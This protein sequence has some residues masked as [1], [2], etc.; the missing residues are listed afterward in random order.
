MATVPVW[1]CP[2]CEKAEVIKGVPCKQCG[3][4]LTSN[5]PKSEI[6]RMALND[7]FCDAKESGTDD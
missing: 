3:F 5:G 2:W 4:K 1:R 6:T 7:E